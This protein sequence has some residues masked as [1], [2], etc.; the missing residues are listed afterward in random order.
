M[1]SDS[2]K[3]IISKIFI[4]RMYFIYM[5]KD[6]LAVVDMPYNQTKPNLSFHT[7]FDPIIHYNKDSRKECIL[8]K[9]VSPACRA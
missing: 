5:Y 6:D 8:P 4:N 7:I 1:N 9:L 3:D 2:F